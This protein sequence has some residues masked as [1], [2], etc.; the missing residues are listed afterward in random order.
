MQFKQKHY[1]CFQAQNKK[2]LQNI[3][4]VDGLCKKA[5]TTGTGFFCIDENTSLREVSRNEYIAN[6]LLNVFA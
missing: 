5:L 1:S 4:C 2:I 3:E 6:T